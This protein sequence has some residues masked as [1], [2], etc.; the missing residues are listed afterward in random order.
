MAKY[1]ERFLDWAETKVPGWSWSNEHRQAFL[2]SVKLHDIGKIVTPL[3]VM[4]KSDRLAEKMERIEERF[5]RMDLLDRIA[6]LEGNM[7]EETTSTT[8][9]SPV[10]FAHRTSTWRSSPVPRS[11]S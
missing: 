6:F 5:R 4:D 3:A 1:A 10:A 2:L 8:R 11:S 7:T 9:I